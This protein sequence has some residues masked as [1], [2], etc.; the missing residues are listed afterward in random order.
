MAADAL[1]LVTS[2]M[3]APDRLT[4]S[5]ESAS[6]LAEHGTLL[7]HPGPRIFAD[8]VPVVSRRVL[9]SPG[10]FVCFAY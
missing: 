9:R 2:Y 7:G 6:R 5:A 10:L 8:G 1:D 3:V 4:A